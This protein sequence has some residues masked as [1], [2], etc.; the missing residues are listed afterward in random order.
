LTDGESNG[1]NGVANEVVPQ[2]VGGVRMNRRFFYVDPM[3]NKT[4]DYYPYGWGSTSD[5]TNTLLRVLKDRTNCN[6]VGFYLYDSNNFKRLDNEFKV[7]NG[8]PD[9]YMKAR[10]FWS[11]NKYYPVKSAGYDEYY[12]I[13]TRS[14]SD[15]TNNLEI[16][17]TGEKKMTVKRMTAAFSK[18][19]QKKTVN[20]VLLRQ[21]VDR[22]ATH[23]KKVA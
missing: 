2:Q 17:N 4:Y 13:D 23:S 11:E 14:M 9:A 19:A 21:F 18:F 7:S 3:T 16:D 10:K 5:N 8:N 12:I 15:D 6:L 22:I 1:S 20:R